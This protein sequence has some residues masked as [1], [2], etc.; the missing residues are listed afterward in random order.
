MCVTLVDGRE[1][2]I[3]F[4]S[5]S[6]IC[7]L[8]WIRCGLDPGTWNTGMSKRDVVPAFMTGQSREDSQKTRKPE[9]SVNHS[10]FF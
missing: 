1:G 3:T 2:S 7:E 6:D 9:S 5:S 8:S 10:V 4:I